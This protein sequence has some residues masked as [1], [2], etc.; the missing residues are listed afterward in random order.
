METTRIIELARAQGKTMALALN[1]YKK[2]DRS[3]DLEIAKIG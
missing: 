1:T 2:V 3:P